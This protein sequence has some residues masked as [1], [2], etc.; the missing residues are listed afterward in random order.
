[1]KITQSEIDEYTEIL[2][3]TP[4]LLAELT[5]GRDEVQLHAKP[6]KKTWSANDILAHLRS[7]ADVWGQSITAMLANENPSLADVHPRKWIRQTD[8]CELGFHQSLADFSR[9]RGMLAGALNGLVW[10]EWSR[11]AGIAGRKHTVFSQARR[12]AK[13][14]IGHIE[15]IRILLQ[16]I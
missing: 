7:C 4:H 15:Q 12:M 1:M 10:E 16:G 8:Y 13:H 6:D 14:E 3:Q 2:R 9:Q 11:G 5:A